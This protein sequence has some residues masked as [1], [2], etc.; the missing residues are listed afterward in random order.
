MILVY[1]TLNLQFCK[2]A[3]KF[4]AYSK[5]PISLL[6]CG[7]H[8][9]LLSLGLSNSL[10]VTLSPANI[11]F[12]S[13]ILMQVFLPISNY[14]LHFQDKSLYAGLQ[15]LQSNWYKDY[16]ELKKIFTVVI[17]P[18]LLGSKRLSVRRSWLEFG[19]QAKIVWGRFSCRASH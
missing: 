10:V 1:Y 7:L 19:W 2:K 15:S 4:W 5:F 8:S 3:W 18:C 11:L 16:T 17:F 12:F 9:L 14:T 13:V 6:K